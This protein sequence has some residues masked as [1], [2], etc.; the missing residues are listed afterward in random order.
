MSLP[1]RLATRIRTRLVRPSR[2]TVSTRTPTR[3]GFLVS[4]ST[5]CTLLMW[6]GASC[7]MIPPV[8]LPRPV[9]PTLVCFLIRL[10]PSTSTRWVSGN[11]GMTLPVS[12][13]YP[14][15]AFAGPAM[16]WTV[17]P[18]LI[19]SF[20]ISEHLRSQCNNLHE[21]LVAQL[22]AH[23]AEDAGA[24]RVPVV[25]E[26]DGGVLVEADVR[27][28]GTAALLDGADDDGLAAL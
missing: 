23:G 22:A 15:L 7:V 18:F 13:R 14:P 20:R 25:A 19:R 10:M 17:S 1:E 3:V 24:A 12:P 16:T 4:G 5:S 26:D 28:V 9:V 27:A 6:I 11:T 2:S 8:L 21:L